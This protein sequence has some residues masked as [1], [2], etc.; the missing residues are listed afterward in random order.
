MKL[1]IIIV[2]YNVRYYLEQCLLSVRRA[3]QGIEA[4]VIVVDNH[5]QDGSMDYLPPRFPEVTFVR[6]K[7]NLGFARANNKAIVRSSGEYVLLLNPDTVVG[8]D[9]LREC[10]AFL[11][12]HPDAG[13][14]GV[15]M[16]KSDGSDAKESRRGVPTPLTSFYKMVGLCARFPRSKVFGKYYMGYLPWDEPSRIEI[17]SGAFCMLRREGLDKVGLLDEDFFMYGEDIDLSYRLLQGG[18]HNWYL[19]VRILHYKGEST[20]KS[21]FRYVHVFYEAMLIFLGKHYGNLSLLLTLPIRLGI[22]ARAAF[23]LLAMLASRARRSLGFVGR[24]QR[25]EPLYCFDVAEDHRADCMQLVREY[26]LRACWVGEGGAALV[27]MSD[28]GGEPAGQDCPMDVAEDGARR[29]YYVFDI[30]QYTFMDV[31]SRMSAGEDRRVQMA[32]YNPDNHIIVTDTE[33]LC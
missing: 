20:Q 26:G 28:H 9:V 7:H 2:S 6:G 30:S 17:V 5:S 12:A 22:Y 25:V 29:V 10:V 4:E 15:R 32:F 31:L 1:S 14:A 3:V 33:V 16:L 18:W 13:A 24:R 11:D 8:E 21:S 27:P 23:T 19:P